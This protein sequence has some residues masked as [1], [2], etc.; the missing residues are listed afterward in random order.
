MGVAHTHVQDQHTG[1]K[2][3]G[4]FVHAYH[5]S[6]L[7][8]CGICYIKDAFDVD[9]YTQ[10]VD[11]VCNDL[12]EFNTFVDTRFQVLWVALGGKLLDVKWLVG[13]WL[14]GEWLVGK[15]LDGKLLVGKLWVGKLYCLF[16]FY[17]WFGCLWKRCKWRGNLMGGIRA[18]GQQRKRFAGQP[19]TVGRI[20]G[21]GAREGGFMEIGAETCR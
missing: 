7:H 9:S 1:H 11:K 18:Q 17:R 20:H 10:R 21:V 5:V 14:V 4:V 8:W 12:H 13:K 3:Q 15:L 2:H 19:W 16:N 6:R